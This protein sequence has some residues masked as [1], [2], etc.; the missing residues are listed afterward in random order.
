MDHMIS[1]CD[2]RGSALH[3]NVRCTHNAPNLRRYHVSVHNIILVYG[4]GLI[5]CIQIKVF[6]ACLLHCIQT[7]TLYADCY[8]GGMRACYIVSS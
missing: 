6:Y 2:A 3:R 8:P 5:H 1:R 4:S 7:D